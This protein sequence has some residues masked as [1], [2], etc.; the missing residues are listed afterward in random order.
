LS[1]RAGAGGRRRGPLGLRALVAL[2]VLVGSLLAL[3]PGAAAL[4][5][6]KARPKVTR[7]TASVSLT[8]ADLHDRLT[9]MPSLP[10]SRTRPSLPIIS[11]HEGIHYQML[12]GVGGAMTDTSAWLIQEEI[13]QSTRDWLLGRLF[14]PHGLRL[15]FMR[16][17]MGASDFTANGTPYSYDDVPVGQ[18]DP[19]LEHFSIHHDA[20]YVIPALLESLAEN[21]NSFVVA[22]P[23]SPPAWMKT[24]DS[25]SNRGN[26]GHLK[27]SSYGPLAQYF[28]KFIDAY[29]AQGIDVDAVT[30]QNEPGQQTA[31]PGMN[32]GE[33]GEAKFIGQYL[34]PTLRAAGLQTQIYGYD[35][36]WGALN[37]PFAYTLLKSPVV[38]DL[39][40]VA[41]HCYFGSPTVMTTMHD[42]APDLDE[43][44]SECS[45]GLLRFSDSELEISAIRNWASAVEL[46]NFALDPSGGPV[47]PPNSGCKHCTGIVT[48]DEATHKVILGSN[49]Y[50][51]GQLSKYVDAGAERIE[52]NNFVTYGA[53]PTAGQA[54]ATAGL[55]D[56]AF[57]NPDGSRVLLAFNGSPA[58]VHFGVADDGRYFTYTLAAGATVTFTWSNT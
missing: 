43:V 44:V 16:I 35:G 20:A 39:A 1:S 54:I 15:N 49:Y 41:T 11:V 32:L 57:Q 25:L 48:I 6:A 51:L 33:Q 58:P 17:P 52:S 40:G 10:F 7:P 18:S 38:N 4:A 5:K 28:V 14:G 19:T 30:P 8:T 27:P 53:Y 2:A 31:Y 34:L 12:K 23:W 22:A 42:M 46:W 13:S 37:A 9:P 29:A 50:Q 26:G 36:I 56:V 24:N 45:P 3:L 55:D 21:P 47:E